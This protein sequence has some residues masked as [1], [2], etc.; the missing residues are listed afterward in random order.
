[1][2]RYINTF[3]LSCLIFSIPA[4]AQKSVRPWIGIHIKQ[5]DK[6]VL[7]Q[8][9][10]KDTPGFRAGLKT[11]DI[12]TSI[13]DIMVKSPSELIKIVQNKG[14][15][16]KV[17]IKYLTD[18][19]EIKVTTLALEAM[20]GLTE[21]AK[22]RLLN[23]KAPSFKG[24]IISGSNKKEY[25]LTDDKKVKIIE[26][27]ATWCGACLQAHP[28]M[29]DFAKKNKDKITVV[30]ISHEKSPV[31]RKYL[32]EAEK[33]KLLS[34]SVIFVNEEDEKISK[35]YLVPALPMFL[36]LDKNNKVRFLTVGVGQEL[37]KAFE[38]AMKL[39]KSTK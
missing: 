5:H 31:I 37:I 36:V 16:Y 13:D 1:M 4:F 33:H 29:N 8:S 12:I 20:P 11:G 28:Y 34:N 2:F 21:V 25:I 15:G 3:L 18:S 7:I 38:M 9:A 26:F 14:V 32:K 19:N 22:K 24:K 35:D 23:N 39:S 6:G 10:V 27:W 30:A 17:K